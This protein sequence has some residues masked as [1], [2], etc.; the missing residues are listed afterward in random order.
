VSTYPPRQCGIA[1]FTG[2]LSRV[3]PD[4]EI[5]A[6][7][8]AEPIGA[9]AFEVHHRIR[10]DEPDDYARTAESL[11]QCADVAAIQFG[12]AIWGGQD[13][14]SVL[15][16]MRALKLP[17]VATLHTLPREPSS[18]QREIIGE[19]VES[20][21]A[22]VVMSEAAADTLR[23]TYG[24]DRD[25]VEVVP[26]GV[27][28]LPIMAAGSIKPIVGLAGRDV[29]L[30][31]GLLTPGK[32][33]ELL[34]DALPAI[35]A[36]HPN[37]TYVILGATH[38]DVRLRDGEAYRVS[39]AGRAA[40]LRVTDHV[41]FVPEFVGRVELAR[42]VQAADVFVAPTPNLDAMVSGTVAFAMAAGRSIVSTGSP[43]AMEML[44]EGRGVV[45][46]PTARSLA[47]E[48]IRLLGDEPARL[49]MGALAHEHSRDAVWTHVGATYQELFAR[50]ASGGPI[51]VRGRQKTGALRG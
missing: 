9:Y 44:A 25:L 47:A 3:S 50:V 22:A 38:P 36:A 42:W 12:D 51:A 23:T 16:F 30:S 24:I 37:T 10:R 8:P 46:E 31:F 40:K 14:E 1:T 21:R 2:D 4:R 7:H 27:P 45:A 6:L 17:A 13:G 29:I 43:Y 15:D 26:Y 19:L 49:A 41:R 39:L 5:V 28:D 11:R 18:R 34:I 35:V 33:Y 32:G 48:V 20:A